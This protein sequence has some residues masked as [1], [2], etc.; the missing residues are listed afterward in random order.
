MTTNDLVQALF[1][2]CIGSPLAILA[3]NVQRMRG[4]T[5]NILLVT[6]DLVLLLGE[7]DF[8]RAV[9]RLDEVGGSLGSDVQAFLGRLLRQ[10]WVGAGDAVRIADD[11]IAPCVT[12]LL[13]L[14]AFVAIPVGLV[15]P[16]ATYHRPLQ[17]AG[18]AIILFGLV[19]IAGLLTLPFY[20]DACK[21]RIIRAI[22]EVQHAAE[23]WLFEHREPR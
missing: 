16:M 13:G 10:P 15:L 7:G 14:V 20:A 5:R 17:R 21:L 9:S 3:W 2:V 4:K 18:L 19:S 6:E 1:A 8:A 11:H 23:K 12:R 22:H